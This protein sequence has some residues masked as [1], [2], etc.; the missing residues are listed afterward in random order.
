MILPTLPNLLRYLSL[1]TRHFSCEKHDKTGTRDLLLSG[2][3]V[4]F[5]VV[6]G[7]G[8]QL[9]PLNMYGQ[10]DSVGDGQSVKVLYHFGL[11]HTFYD[12]SVNTLFL[13]GV[14][15]VQQ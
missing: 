7:Y 11:V 4:L 3:V 5:I 2:T 10:A 6:Q 8:Q 9:F 1:K 15:G 13:S 14:G 12:L